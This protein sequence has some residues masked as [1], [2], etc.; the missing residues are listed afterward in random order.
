[1]EP[2]VTVRYVVQWETLSG[3]WNDWV[4]D[5][6]SPVDATGCATLDEAKALRDTLHNRDGRLRIVKRTEEVVE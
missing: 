6:L 5:S 1:M 3:H 2:G 4:D